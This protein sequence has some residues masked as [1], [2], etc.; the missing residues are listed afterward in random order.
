MKVYHVSKEKEFSR[1]DRE[2]T[3]ERV[4]Q[5][6]EHLIKDGKSHNTIQKYMGDFQK[7][8]E[9]MDGE[10]LSAQTM[11]EY[12]EWLETKDYKR[13]SINSYLAAA[14]KFCEI[15]GWTEMKV[16]G[17]RLKLEDYDTKAKH[18]SVS[19]YRKLV[20]TARRY[21]MEDV[22]MIIQVLCHMDIRFI[23]LK[24]LTVAAL[25]KGY[26]EVKRKGTTCASYLPDVVKQDLERY[27][28]QYEIISGIIF[29]T[30]N[31][32]P[33]DRSN[34][35]KKLKYICELANV[36]PDGVSINK[37]KKPDVEDYYPYVQG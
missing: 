31:G 15:M 9:F 2:I 21:D 26:V 25:K 16:P 36:D 28:I 22:A 32:N 8:I 37:M 27:S 1:M 35:S 3:T 7:L 23:E 4:A 11:A 20:S 18:I 10:E 30:K 17:I 34:F 6:R 29:R 24:L 19:V 14:N 12:K 13:R 5:F 33:I